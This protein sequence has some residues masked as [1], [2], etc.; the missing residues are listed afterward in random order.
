M[1]VTKSTKSGKKWMAEF[2]VKP[3]ERKITHFG[4]SKYQDYTQHHD[5]E[6][7]DNYRT[8]HKK[9]LDTKDPTRAGFLS[10][11]ILWGD[12]TDIKKNIAEYKRKYN[13]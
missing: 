6:R 9:D 13:L 12:H 3:T 2:L 8:R 7:R 11:Y 1:S 5:K 4:D 10:Y